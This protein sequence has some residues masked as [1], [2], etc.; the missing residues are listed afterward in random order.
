M[1]RVFATFLAFT[2]IC[3]FLRADDKEEFRKEQA[4]STAS[5]QREAAGADQDGQLFVRGERFRGLM[6][7]WPKTDSDW[8][9]GLKSKILLYTEQE[10]PVAYQHDN[11]VHWAFYNISGN[12]NEQRFGFGNA[13]REFPWGAPAGLHASEN[14]RV[15]RFVHLPSAIKVWRTQGKRDIYHE[16]A[17]PNGTVF[18]EILTVGASDKEHYTFEV[19]VRERLG[20]GDWKVRVYRPYPGREDLAKALE[21]HGV[22][23]A[24]A[25]HEKQRLRSKHPDSVAF[26][27]TANVAE[28]PRLNPE[29]ARSLLSGATFKPASESWDQGVAAPTAKGFNIVPD[30]YHG[31]Y[32]KVTKQS[33]MGCHEHTLRPVDDFDFRRDWYGRVRGSDNIFSFHVFD[34]ASISDN[35]FRRPVRLRAELVNAG[36][37]EWWR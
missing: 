3:L 17:Y 19:R 28:L 34:P 13:N 21:R 5:R 23:L 11:G 30:N 24:V 10:M 15:L 4:R 14:Y 27:R 16:W 25:V 9:N 6:K 18:G 31:G 35:G 7:Y 36:L 1:R 22:D 12:A 29:V 20:K 33:C 32:I 8:F 2:S 26:D 37:L